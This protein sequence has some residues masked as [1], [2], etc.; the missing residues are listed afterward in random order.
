MSRIFL[1]HSSRNNA[2]AVALFDWLQQN[3]WTD[4]FLDL[5]PKRGIVAGERWERALHEAADRCEAVLF[6]VSR[7][8]LDSAW[9]LKEFSLADRLNKHIFIVLIED[10]KIDDL[11]PQLTRDF[12]VTNLAAGRDHKVFYPQLPDGSQAESV[13]FSQS[14][15]E[16]LT[17][18]LGAAG[19]DQRHF[20]F[21]P[22]D[23]PDRSPYR[24]LRP[25]EAEDAGIF[26]GR[27]SQTVAAL[28]RLRGLRDGHDARLFVILGASGAGK[29][30][31]LRAGLLPR[32][33]RDDRHFVVLP[34]IRPARASISGET[35]F[36]S[37]L[38]AAMRERKLKVSKAE[39]EAAVAGGSSAVAPR[40]DQLIAAATVSIADE[41]VKLPPP[42]PVIAIDQA[43][44]LFT[45]DAGAEA[46]ALLALI[47]DLAA[48]PQH[49]VLF[50]FTIRSDNYDR[51]Q[52]A[53]A[54]AG[55]KQEPFSLPPVPRGNY[56]RIILGPAEVLAETDRALNIEPALVNAVLEDVD[57]G[58]GKDALPLI[59]FTMERLYA[60]HGTDG[61]LTA[62]EY[63]AMGRIRGSIE[64]AV[65]QALQR[66]ADD[67]QLPRVET[68]RLELL[69]KGLIPWLAEIDPETQEPRRRVARVS[70]IPAESLP[71]V[72]HLVDAALLTTDQAGDEATIEPAHEAVL[73]QWPLLRDWLK[74]DA[75]LLAALDGVKRAAREWDQNNRSAEWLSHEGGRLE[76]AERLRLRPDLG[77]ILDS[78]DVAAIYLAR[79]REREDYRRNKQM[80]EAKA[81]ADS[82]ALAARN[83]ELAAERA[84]LVAQRTLAGLA[85]AVVLG[86]VALGLFLYSS[87]QT[88]EA[89]RQA[90]AAEKSA[91]TAMQMT[92][93]AEEQTVNANFQTAVAEVEAARSATEQGLTDRALLLLLDAASKRE[94]AN[95]LLLPAEIRDLVGRVTG[96]MYGAGPTVPERIPGIEAALHNAVEKAAQV[97]FLPLP[98]DIDAF[99]TPMELVLADPVSNAMWRIT[100]APEPDPILGPYEHARVLAVARDGT[101]LII[102]RENG[103]IEALED[104]A[105]APTSIAFASVP[106]L[107]FGLDREIIVGGGVLVW[108][109]QSWDNGE[110]WAALVN[111]RDGRVMYVSSEEGGFSDVV[112]T[113]GGEQVLLGYAQRVG[114]PI[115]WAQ[116]KPPEDGPL[117][118]FL[119]ELPEARVTELRR[120]LCSRDVIPFR[121]FGPIFD[122][123]FGDRF[124][125]M[126]NVSG[127]RHAGAGLIVERYSASSAGDLRDDAFISN[128]D[129]S[130]YLDPEGSPPRYVLSIREV[131]NAGLTTRGLAGISGVNET[132]VGAS[133]GSSTFG[134]IVGR[135]LYLADMPY[136]SSFLEAALRSAAGS[137]VRN[138]ESPIAAQRIR[139]PSVPS[140]A[141]FID[142]EQVAVVLPDIGRLAIVTPTHETPARVA[143]FA[144]VG[145]QA[146]VH[147]AGAT[148]CEPLL[149]QTF[150]PV[151][152]SGEAVTFSDPYTDAPAEER[153]FTIGG[154]F[155]EYGHGVNCVSI[156]DDLTEL[157]VVY[158]LSDMSTNLG[159][160]DLQE[161]LARG[162]IA[163]LG[164]RW[165]GHAQVTTARYLSGS[166]DLIA[167]RESEA[168]IFRRDADGIVSEE[169]V[170]YRS[171]HGVLS[172]DLS[173]D[174]QSLAVVEM[175]GQSMVQASVYDM[176]SGETLVTLGPYYKFLEAALLDG[177]SALGY[178][179]NTGEFSARVMPLPTLAQLLAAARAELSPI[180]APATEGDY[181][182]SPCWNDSV[183]RPRALAAAMPPQDPS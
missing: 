147:Q 106:D 65:R 34:P 93:V 109:L 156:S 84:Q 44:E 119:D 179:G 86:V 142:G 67:P 162:S 58:D 80:D 70:E 69:R 175:T 178:A 130:L 56:S 118:I 18:G 171:E 48:R 5:D 50:L 181:A 39:I 63:E 127:C 9:C 53:K 139:L 79:C 165:I 164:A 102:A 2:Q 129:A 157:A 120:L 108:Q 10:L 101:R 40:L 136:G 113:P 183:T 55:L 98:P 111:L 54:L 88:G 35:G 29:S 161:A 42:T 152:P 172:A 114:W 24:G 103:D 62:A 97:D 15:L 75:A 61:D 73:R 33:A 145:S 170:I 21:P 150:P 25:L 64:A 128:E 104:G 110:T 124:G 169:A 38:A 135:D 148:D 96:A 36:A 173:R 121:E 28:D 14:G 155:V 46:E 141:R 174:Q 151:L 77:A 76:D 123:T 140:V 176:H 100:N 6:L 13:T 134:S 68:E 146:E 87:F 19:L 85:I 72:R 1:S 105:A 160:V 115:D 91:N 89:Q 74:A 180:C 90:E 107:V 17:R 122:Q 78:T 8:W 45:A 168:V 99:E 132:W 166:H 82:N 57:R 131:L 125:A 81:L 163:D 11:P 49:Q 31:F 153:G 95:A 66:A 47:A 177:G 3:H 137:P 126:Y 117:R 92:F 116:A 60:E 30:S 51:L 59:A 94:R 83:A 52:N 143:V 7:A 27:E 37:A 71:M 149:S 159:V 144:Q 112:E 154:N 32:L 23:D 167:A 41:A 12:Q 138:S 22:P 26:F 4:I 182:S 158:S 133:A 20:R 16:R 43:E